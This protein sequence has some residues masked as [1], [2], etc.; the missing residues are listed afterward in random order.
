MKPA[1]A[2]V[3]GQIYGRF[4]EKMAEIISKIGVRK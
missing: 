2:A 4:I 3:G 1:L